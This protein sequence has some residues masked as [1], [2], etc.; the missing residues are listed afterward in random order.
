MREHGYED[1][2]E[3]IQQIEDTYAAKGTKS[4]RS[5]WLALAG[6]PA[7]RCRHYEGITLPI[8]KAARQREGYPPAEGAIERTPGEQA[9]KKQAQGRWGGRLRSDDGA[10]GA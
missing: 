8:L 6:T 9:P 1:I 5:W 3:L 10:D 2:D 4:R 7:G